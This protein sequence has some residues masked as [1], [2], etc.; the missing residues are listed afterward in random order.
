MQQ[1]QINVTTIL[2]AFEMAA[3]AQLQN[4]VIKLLTKEGWFCNKTIKMSKS[5]WP[6]V[7]AISPSG[8][9]LWLEIKGPLGRVS[10]IQAWTMQQ[11]WDRGVDAYVIHN[12]QEVKDLM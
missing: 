12:L 8:R 4:N 6:D 3:E 7:I 1:C 2:R 9:H 11:M 5:G 10:E